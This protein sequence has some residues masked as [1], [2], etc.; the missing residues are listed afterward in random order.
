[1]AATLVRT[2]RG[3]ASP[4]VSSRPCTCICTA[5][6]CSCTST[7]STSSRPETMAVPPDQP[8]AWDSST[9]RAHRSAQR[10]AGSRSM[11]ATG[12]DAL[13]SAA[14]PSSS[15]ASR[16]WPGS[17]SRAWR[18][19]PEAETRSWSTP[20]HPVM[21]SS[22]SQDRQPLSRLSAAPGL[23][24]SGAVG[25]GSGAGGSAQAARVRPSAAS[26]LASRLSCT[27]PSSAVRPPASAARCSSA[28]EPAA[29]FPTASPTR[30]PRGVVAR[31][32]A[33]A[34]SA[35]AGSSPRRANPWTSPWSKPVT[36]SR[37]SATP[38]RASVSRS[39]S[40]APSISGP[41]PWPGT[42]AARVPVRWCRAVPG[43]PGGA[44]TG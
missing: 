35:A 7:P 28:T 3:G 5:V 8:P 29:I 22:F 10:R 24:G 13:S 42:S 17:A 11:V 40:C 6:P 44:G 15:T 2:S 16:R 4:A 19:W 14:R 26:R 34:A 23:A 37:A 30:S 38:G 27:A 18:I 39:A 9:A 1:M 31:A 43:T 33:R 32:P 41:P 20:R 25:S 21:A 36:R 12:H